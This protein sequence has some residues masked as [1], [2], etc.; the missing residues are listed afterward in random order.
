MF[1]YDSSTALTDTMRGPG[2]IPAFEKENA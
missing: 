1:D 2:R